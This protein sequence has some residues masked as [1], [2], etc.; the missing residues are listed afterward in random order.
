MNIK[1]FHVGGACFVLDVD[2]KIKIACDPFLKPE[3]TEYNFKSF[4]SKRVKPPIYDDS[5]FTDIKVWMITHGHADHIDEVG[6]SK[7]QEDSVVIAC[8]NAVDIL[9]GKRLSSLW[10]LD[11]ND[12]REMNIGQYKV[13]IRVIPAFHGN[14]LITRT[15]VGKVNGYYITISY[16]NEKKTIYVTSDTVYHGK[17]LKPLEK[18]KIDILIAN[19]GEVR[20]DMNGGPLTMSV[21]MLKQMVNKIS[22]R[23][24][25]P[26]HYDDFTHYETS[27]DEIESQGLKVFNQG[28][29]ISLL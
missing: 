9:S 23:V 24:V 10:V 15:L 29:W 27:K 21:P 6:V 13:S 3:G 18:E 2:E 25:V 7:I 20:K 26:I 22:P 28:E 8:K 12:T 16:G 19:L 11:W 4:K 14:S 17:V 5:V 1:I